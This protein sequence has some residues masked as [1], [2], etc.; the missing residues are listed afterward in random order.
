[1]WLVYL[2]LL[3]SLQ[4]SGDCSVGDLGS[5]GNVGNRDVVG[6]E[7]GNDIVHFL[8]GLGVGVA[9][10]HAVAEEAGLGSELL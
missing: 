4:T 9:C 3:E 10:W 1:M 5:S 6:A 8:V 2:T 7:L